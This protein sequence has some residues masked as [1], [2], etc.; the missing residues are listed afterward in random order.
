MKKIYLLGLASMVALGVNAQNSVK[1]KNPFKKP[2]D[3]SHIN[4]RNV[5]NGHN[6][7]QQI[8]AT[9]TCNSFYVTGSAFDLN[10]VLELQY[11]TSYEFGDSLAITFPGSVTINSTTNMPDLGPDDG[12]GPDGPEA[13]DGIFGQTI[14]WGNDDNTYG[15]ITPDGFVGAIPGGYQITIN[16]TV[17]PGTMGN[18]TCN[19]H[20]DGDEYSDDGTPAADF[21]GTFDILPQPAIDLGLLSVTLPAEGCGMSS[22]AP[23]SVDI[24]N[25]GAND[26]SNFNISYIVNGGTPVV[27]TY[28]GTVTSGS[29]LSYTFTTTADFSAANDYNVFA[30]VTATGDTYDVNDT[31]S[32]MTSSY[33]LNAIPY[34]TS[35][36]GSP[37]S[38]L[39]NWRVYN[40]DGTL[41]GWQLDNNYPNSGTNELLVIENDGTNPVAGL[42]DQ[43]AIS[44]CLDMMAGTTY[45]VRYWAQLPSA[46]F[47]CGIEIGLGSTQSVAGMTSTIKSLTVPS[48]AG[49]YVQDSADFTVAS[50]GTYYM[51]F[52]AQ[53]T[54]ATAIAAIMLDDIE[55]VAL[56]PIGI[57][58]TANTNTIAIFPN[59]SNGVF[60]V[61]AI[62]NSSIT[63]YS[64]I[65]ENVYSA[66]LVKGNNAVDLS[67]MAPGTYIVKIKAGNETTTK[68][69]VINK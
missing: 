26:V 31:M 10:L 60:T 13:F 21:D 11:N 22:T 24:H 20:V 40:V 48:P 23:I 46:S 12:S 37:A 52:R 68:R 59:P 39:E 64:V 3:G 53:N 54:N 49:G 7:V 4:A 57:K 50:S 32:N 69:V 1:V 65:G 30:M 43:W 45:R 29:T 36:E 33:T 9:M 61:K 5:G 17:A 28:T 47:N 44:S 8:D 41:T 6:S 35:F 58:E 62:D 51:G 63:V 25:G 55:I 38:D 16:I 14:A 66:N 15:G 27:E 34:A 18:I 2:V 67:N 56:P 19:Y 42:S